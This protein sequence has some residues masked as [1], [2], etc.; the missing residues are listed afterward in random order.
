MG[1]GVQ[2]MTKLAIIFGDELLTLC[3]AFNLIIC[4]DVD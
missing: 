2:K 1:D 4:N 3:V